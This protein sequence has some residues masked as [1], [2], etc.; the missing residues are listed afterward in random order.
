M[1]RSQILVLNGPNLNLLGRRKVEIYGTETLSQIEESLRREGLKFECDVDTNH[2]SNSESDL[3]DWIHNTFLHSHLRQ[4][5]I[6]LNAAGFTHTS[7][8]LREAIEAAA[9]HGIPTV[10]VHLSNPDI[11]ARK[12]GERFRATNYIRDVCAKTFKGEK[13]LSYVKALRW[14]VRRLEQ[15]AL[16][17]LEQ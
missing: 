7:V 16:K 2:Q 9:E 3:I 14:L 17:A 13:S 6:I 10:E 12:R 11:R 5:G 4:D 1:T 15:D 8:A